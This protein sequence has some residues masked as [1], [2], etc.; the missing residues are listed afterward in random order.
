MISSALFITYTIMCFLGLQAMTIVMIVIRHSESG[1]T[2]L[3]CAMRNFVIVS[4]VLGGFYYITYYKEL[5]LGIFETSVPVRMLDAVIFYAHGFCW[6]RLIDAIAEYPTMKYEVLRRWTT[7]VF[8]V[9]MA[10]SVAVY[11]FA[12]DGYYAP[13]YFWS[14]SVV[15]I[16]EVVLALTIIC[17]TVC[18]AKPALREINEQN[19]RWYIILVSVLINL[20]NIWN[21]V[22]VSFVFLRELEVSLLCSYLYAVISILLLL[23]NLLTIV[24]VYKK[25]FS[26]LY[27]DKKDQTEPKA[28][29][30]EEELLDVIAES[31]RLTERERDVMILAYRGLT[32]PDIAEQLFISKHTVKRHMHNVFEKLDVSN[33]MELVHLIRAKEIEISRE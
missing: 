6:I 2:K 27:F 24:Y 14:E 28:V 29:M 1:K 15:L 8:G 18:Y 30:T 4:I 12:I 19:S 7:P 23:I 32:N 25:D 3:M 5:V 11:V 20:N 16:F 13:K 17:F 31:H 26:P 22:V 33:R 21:N 9:L 10:V